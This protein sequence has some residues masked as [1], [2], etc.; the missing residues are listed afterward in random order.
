M[1]PPPSVGALWLW[2]LVIIVPLLIQRVSFTTH[3][4][5]R[6]APFARVDVILPA[7]HGRRV[8]VHHLAG[9]GPLADGALCSL[10]QLNGEVLPPD[11]SCAPAG[12]S[13]TRHALSHG[14]VS[15]QC[16]ALRSQAVSFMA[17][18]SGLSNTPHFDAGAFY[19]LVLRSPRERY[20]A[21]IDALTADQVDRLMPLRNSSAAPSRFDI[22]RALSN[23]HRNAV[24]R[25]L[26]DNALVRYLAGTTAREMPRRGVTLQHMLGAQARLA[27]FDALLFTDDTQRNVA[28]LAQRLGWR[29]WDVTRG[30]RRNEAE[31]DNMSAQVEALPRAERMYLD[32]LVVYD[33]QLYKAAM[34]SSH[35]QA[36]KLAV[37]RTWSNTCSDRPSIEPA[38]PGLWGRDW[39][40]LTAVL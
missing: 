29:Y 1:R 4:T 37:E 20:L 30:D 17:F 36:L 7:R 6:A 16:V 19:V 2:L 3:S 21:D 12:G 38:P 40:P 25:H 13:D 5:P 31:G 27:R 28:L 22:L 10:A 11:G 8:V 9:P 33:D 14:T 34:N 24:P 26:R 18:S 32:S 15:E 39:A 23:A 35:I